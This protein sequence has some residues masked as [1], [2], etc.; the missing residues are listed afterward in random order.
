[1][2]TAY[3]EPREAVEAER[4]GD[5]RRILE[6]APELDSNVYGD[7]EAEEDSKLLI[8]KSASKG[9]EEIVRLLLDHGAS[10]AADPYCHGRKS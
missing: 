10:P 2:S 7:E 6:T 8:E 9:N 5:V 4:V 3:H 1:M